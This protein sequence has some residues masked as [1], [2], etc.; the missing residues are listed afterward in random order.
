M[1]CGTLNSRSAS[2]VPPMTTTATSRMT[3]VSRCVRPLPR[4]NELKPAR[5]GPSASCFRLNF[6]ILSPRTLST[7]PSKLRDRQIRRHAAS[8]D[9]RL[10]LEDSFDEIWPCL[11]LHGSRPRDVDIVNRSDAARARRHDD[12]PVC[13]K[14]GFG[15]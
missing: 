13:K 9:P 12:H 1:Y 8:I 14:D 4:L 7:L 11:N 2:S 5:P 10:H 15:N 6:G 3:A